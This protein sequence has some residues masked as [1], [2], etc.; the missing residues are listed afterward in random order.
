MVVTA[1]DDF[2]V[3]RKN[4]LTVVHKLWKNGSENESLF[5][6]P[7]KIKSRIGQTVVPE[8]QIL[9]KIQEGSLRKCAGHQIVLSAILLIPPRC[10]LVTKT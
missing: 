5:P 7:H 2:W 10:L 6:Y 3:N 1:H 4:I 8:T 9:E